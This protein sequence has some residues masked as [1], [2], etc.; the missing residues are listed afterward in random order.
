MRP[1]APHDQRTAS[2]YLFC[3]VCPK[4]GKGAALVLP[5]CNCN[6][7]AMNLHLV[8]IAA[9]WQ[10]MRNNWLSNRV[11]K[12]YHI[13]SSIAVRRNKLNR[14][15]LEVHRIAPM[16][17]WV[18]INGSG[19]SRRSAVENYVSPAVIGAAVSHSI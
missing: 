14:S 3:A 17:A 7:E 19:I 10:F 15:T 9:C 16:G 4:Q 1:R 2:T 12:S 5:A 18:L 6:T 13:S 11:L 8:E